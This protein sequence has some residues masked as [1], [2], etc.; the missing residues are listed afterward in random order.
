[1]IQK[2]FIIEGRKADLELIRCDDQ[3][4]EIHIN[5]LKEKLRFV[6]FFS[7]LNSLSTSDD[8]FEDYISII[9][10]QVEKSSCKT[11]IL[12]PNQN[13]AIPNDD[14]LKKIN[15]LF[16]KSEGKNIPYADMQI[17]KAISKHGYLS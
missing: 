9:D 5:D 7:N 13:I 1:M 3:T 12:F 15:S 17:F 14:R 2:E 11:I 10:Q 8:E 16:L 4:F 6:P